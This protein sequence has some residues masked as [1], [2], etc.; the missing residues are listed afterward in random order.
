MLGKPLS[1]WRCREGWFNVENP[2]PDIA[3]CWV[4]IVHLKLSILHAHTIKDYKLAI[5]YAQTHP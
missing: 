3:A 4:V 2:I 5:F 1:E